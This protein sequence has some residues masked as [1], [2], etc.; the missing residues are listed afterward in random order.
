M[1]VEVT[2][3]LRVKRLV[4]TRPGNW[5]VSSIPVEYGDPICR[6]P[7]MGPV[8]TGA[9]RQIVPLLVNDAEQFRQAPYPAEVREKAQNRSLLP[10]DLLRL[11]DRTELRLIVSGYDAFSGA[12]RLFV[13]KEYTV[14]DIIDGRFNKDG[15]EVIPQ[16]SEPSE[17]SA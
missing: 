1:D 3:R 14:G 16:A 13:S 11:G 6:V 5:W 10:E 7:K 8:R 15:L 4:A 12:R 9:R 17:P 2:A